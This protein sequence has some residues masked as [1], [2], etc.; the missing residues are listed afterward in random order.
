VRVRQLGGLVLALHQ[1]Q[2]GGV[3]RPPGVAYG[4]RRQR[5]EQVAHG[6]LVAD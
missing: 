3:E 1:R 4:G 2:L 6:G 5:R